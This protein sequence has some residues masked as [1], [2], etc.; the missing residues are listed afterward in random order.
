M[1]IALVSGP[2]SETLYCDLRQDT[3]FSHTVYRCIFMLEVTDRQASQLAVTR[4]IPR[5]LK[6]G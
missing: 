3:L 5:Q 2:W 1:I 4:N 6:P